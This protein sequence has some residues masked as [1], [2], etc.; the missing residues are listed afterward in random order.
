MRSAETR[1]QSVTAAGDRQLPGGT[2]RNSF[3]E[4]VSAVVGS[5]R[6]RSSETRVFR[7]G[8]TARTRKSDVFHRGRNVPVAISCEAP[9]SRNESYARRTPAGYPRW[10]NHRIQPSSGILPRKP[11]AVLLVHFAL[12]T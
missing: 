11:A 3:E 4:R 5:N 10:R 1:H 8:S 7:T 9:S 12:S 6:I 2:S